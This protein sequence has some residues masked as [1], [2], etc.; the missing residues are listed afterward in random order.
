MPRGRATSDIGGANQ[1]GLQLDVSTSDHIKDYETRYR[2]YRSVGQNASLGTV[3][4][5]I[6]WMDAL[7]LM[8]T[9]K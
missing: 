7:Y 2:R 4:Y 9:I 3:V 6:V 1:G 8:T 5:L